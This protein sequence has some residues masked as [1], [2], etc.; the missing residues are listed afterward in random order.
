MLR[1]SNLSSILN[2]KSQNPVRK[3]LYLLEVGYWP[4]TDIQPRR[5]FWIHQRSR[6]KTGEEAFD[7]RNNIPGVREHLEARV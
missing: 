5:S 7:Q 4:E 1:Y 3:Q 6:T 2:S